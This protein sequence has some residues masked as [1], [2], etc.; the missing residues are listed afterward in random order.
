MCLFSLSNVKCNTQDHIHYNFII[1]YYINKVTYFLYKVA[2]ISNNNN[3]TKILVLFL[4]VNF[5]YFCPGS[6]IYI[7]CI[8]FVVGIRVS[9]SHNRQRWLQCVYR[10]KNVNYLA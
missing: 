1:L 7:Y 6:L 4:V 5:S 8:T 9:S 10:K 3:K 2:H